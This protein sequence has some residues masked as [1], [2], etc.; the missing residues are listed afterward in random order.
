MSEHGEGGGASQTTEPAAG[1]S[2]ATDIS[3]RE[4]FEALRRADEKYERAKEKFEDE[5][6]RRYS[7]VALE[8][9]KALKI[10]EEADK[11]ALGLAREI[12]QYKDEKANELRE[13]INSERG[14]YA[15]KGDVTSA[16]EKVEASIK[17]LAEYVTAQQGGPRAITS[18]TLLTAIGAFATVLTI[19]A[20]AVSLLLR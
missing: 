8:R 11:A 12:Q 18:G 20:I 14:L 10:K 16:V 5:R 13:Q 15:T 17:P 19:I 9:E 4:Y 6:D 7:E 1:T 2:A 3:I